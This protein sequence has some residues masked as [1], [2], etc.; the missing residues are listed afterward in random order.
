M[1]LTAQTPARVRGYV[2]AVVAVT[3][4][5]ILLAWHLVGSPRDVVAL[6]VLT[7]LGLISWALR[8]GDIGARVQ[9]SFTSVILL[10][11][12]V[13]VG[14][15]GAAIVGGASFAP[16]LFRGR[17]SVAVFNSAMTCLVGVVGG[18]VYHL[19]GG[20]ADIAQLTG[21]QLLGEVGL[22]LM[23][24]DLVQCLA[25]AV[26]LAGVM[27]CN[28]QG[29]FR[30]TTMSLLATSGLAYVGYGVIG[31]LFVILWLPAG[32]GP[33]SAVLVLA[34]LFVARW[35]FAQYGHEQRAHERTLRSLNT[36]LAVKDPVGAAHAERVGE[37]AVAVGVHLGLGH[38]RLQAL[39]YASLMRDVGRLTVPTRLLQR[40]PATATRADR[41]RL[42]GVPAMS[43]ELI[44]DID[45]LAEAADIL[46]VPAVSVDPAPA[47]DPAPAS[48]SVP[49][50]DPAS[51]S[52]P[53]S[54][55]GQASAAPAADVGA[56]S[57]PVSRGRGPLH[58]TVDTGSASPYLEAHI[59]AAALAYH[60]LV[61]PR[62]D[63]P[64]SSPDALHRLAEASWEPAII[65]AL[66]RVV[67]RGA[68]TEEAPAE[69]GHG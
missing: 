38:N 55:R 54:A 24:A 63:T 6:L 11:S 14:P 32:V 17:P 5:C 26:V 56:A 51:A 33:F 23:L 16:E 47:P 62:W 50:C 57:G 1:D 58:R 19:A 52:D 22:P 45:F 27:W 12:V 60:D 3:A 37:L 65:H 18:L 8:E 68:D 31:L 40:D 7:G 67:A 10:A 46:A 29:G 2:A 64:V 41:E 48:D 15:V 4:A 21:G 28:G 43:A 59:L 20:R 42:A 53:T 44:R 25:N 66:R 49:A 34:P 61:N 13:L 36:A 69:A 35:A 9:L 30:A 39:R